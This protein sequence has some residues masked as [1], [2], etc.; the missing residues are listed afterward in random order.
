MQTQDLVGQQFG[1]YRLVRLIGSGGYAEVYLAEHVD[2]NNLQRAIKVLTG[3][4][5]NDEQRAQFLEEARTIAN[6]QSLNSHIVQ[7]H[8]FGIQTS[9]NSA[10]YG[11]PYLVMEYAEGGTLRNL[12]PYNTQVPLDRIVFYTKQIAE[13]LQC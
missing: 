5:L 10:D 12:Y 2:I 6:L 13:A 9:Q 4:S 8:D 11:V 1:N 7:I 3:T